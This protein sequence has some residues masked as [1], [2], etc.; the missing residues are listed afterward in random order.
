MSAESLSTRQTTGPSISPHTAGCYPI[1]IR[2]LYGTAAEINFWDVV[3]FRAY[4][5]GGSFETSTQELSEQTG[6]TRQ[7]VSQLRQAAIEHG[8]LI[9]DVSFTSGHRFHVRISNFDQARKGVIWKPLGYIANGWQHVVTP[10]I[11]KRVLNLYL[12]QPRQ[13]VYRLDARY[14]AGKCQRRF[15][16]ESHQPTGPLNATD[17]SNALRLLLQLGLFTPEED[18]LRIDW[19]VFNRPAPAALPPRATVD[20]REH[21]L[22][23][24]SYTI[25]PVRAER[26][27]EL[28]LA[29]NYEIDAHFVDIF[30]DLAYIHREDDYHLLHKK[31]RTRRNRLP[32]PNRWKETW[33][34]FHSDLKRRASEIRFP[35]VTLNLGETAQLDAPLAAASFQATRSVSAVVMVARVER[36]WYVQEAASVQL[37]VLALDQILF[38]RSLSAEDGEVRF[39]LRPDQWINASEQLLLRACCERPLPGVRVEAWL[40]AKLQ[41]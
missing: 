11:P 8:E 35:K 19:L 21:R 30:R 1:P 26:A 12:Q 15:L 2:F 33:R 31:V 36:L 13:R 14:I 40:E 10:A 4:I 22:F 38:T 37:D 9:E 41:R 23:V 7:M 6:L 17:V 16:Y 3:Y 24:E 34:V 5:E 18:G 29:G 27:L 28:L 20:L 39:T 25:D 32:G